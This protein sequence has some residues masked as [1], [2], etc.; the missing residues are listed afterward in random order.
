[1]CEFKERRGDT[2]DASSESQDGF[3]R[4][5]G[6]RSPFPVVGS[7]GSEA[8]DEVWVSSASD[9]ER[10]KG[11]HVIVPY[12]GPYSIIPLV[13]DIVRTD[14]ATA[15]A[16]GWQEIAGHFGSAVKAVC[17]L[18]SAFISLSHLDSVQGSVS[19]FRNV[20][21]LVLSAVGVIRLRAAVGLRQVNGPAVVL[22]ELTEQGLDGLE[23]CW[24][25]ELDIELKMDSL[26]I[27]ALFELSDDVLDSL[28][29]LAKKSA[30]CDESVTFAIFRSFLGVQGTTPVTHS[31]PNISRHSRHTLTNL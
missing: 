5:I 29:L 28:G 20:T 10:D 9:G 15:M 14:S 31:L 2:I 23:G 13:G 27:G 3:E 21:G 19:S 17:S 24:V 12:V 8:F 25:L 11:P 22:V 26:G 6:D 7:D 1:V 16:V 4:V 30:S 18:S